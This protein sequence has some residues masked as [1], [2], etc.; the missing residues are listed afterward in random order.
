M[1]R[2]NQTRAHTGTNPFVNAS[3]T[4]IFTFNIPDN[5]AFERAEIDIIRP[6][7]GGA[8]IADRPV[9]FD[10]GPGKRIVVSWWIDGGV[11]SI[12]Y[13]IRASTI[14][15]TAATR[16]VVRLMQNITDGTCG[17]YLKQ[18][19]GLVRVAFNE[20]KKFEPA[21]TLKVLHLYHTFSEIERGASA[22]N[23]MVTIPGGDF[24]R[25]A[26]DD[27][28][29]TRE[30]MQ[31]TLRRMM[32]N[33]DNSATE[34]IRRRFGRA[35]I[36]ATAAALGMADTELKHNLGCG[37]APDMGGHNWTTLADL[38]RLY[39]KVA[40]GN[41]FPNNQA[42]FND[43]IQNWVFGEWTAMVDEEALALEAELPGRL[44]AAE[45]QTF[46]NGMKGYFKP[47]G[48]TGADQDAAGR[49]IWGVYQSLAGL[50]VLPFRGSGG[51]IGSRQFCHGV[52]VSNG[53]NESDC[54][55]ARVIGT[56]EVVREEIRSALK[57]FQ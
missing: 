11:G 2:L 18:V 8:R 1:E 27:D 30:T 53:S 37:W 43:T 55:T 23:E 44:T 45:I 52:Y 24:C 31:E 26:E 28:P 16:R 57:T 6:I 41:P 3:G 19:G 42:A 32:R 21:S 48:Y 33:S 36:R 20:S 5:E 15:M 51:T 13:R 17:V 40:S 54:G 7:H 14:P 22:L 12:E 29:Y 47:G 39:E 46:K 35:A 4:D 25:V 49:A 38:G 10:S 9:N 34:A 56:K 50:L